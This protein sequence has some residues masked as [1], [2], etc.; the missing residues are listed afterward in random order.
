MANIQHADIPYE[1]MHNAVT[2]QQGN[3]SPIGVVTPLGIGDTYLDTDDNAVY[4][5][6]GETNT[7]WIMLAVGARHNLT[8]GDAPTVDNDNTEGYRRFSHW[9]DQ[10]QDPPDIYLCTDATTGA[11]EWILVSGT[12]GGGGTETYITANDESGSLPNSDT[13]ANYLDDPGVPQVTLT[14]DGGFTTHVKANGSSDTPAYGLE[15]LWQSASFTDRLTM[16]TGITLRSQAPSVDDV[17]QHLLINYLGTTLTS[18]SPTAQTQ[19][20]AALLL[21]LSR[22][23]I[24]ADSYIGGIRFSLRENEAATTYFLNG[25]WVKATENITFGTAHGTKLVFE[26]VPNSGTSPQER[27]TLDHD[28]EVRFH[29]GKIEFG[30]LNTPGSSSA[31]GDAGQ[32]WVD[33]DYL[34]FWTDDDEVK[35]IPWGA[36]QTPIGGAS[37]LDDLSDVTISTPATG[38][39]LRYN[40]SSWV[41]VANMA[42]LATGTYTGDAAT[43]KAITGAGFQ[44]RYLQIWS[45]INGDVNNIVAYKS[46]QDGTRAFY[47][48]AYQNDQ[49]I[50]LD[51]DGFTVGD[52]T[53]A[54]ASNILNVSAR[55]Y[56]WVAFA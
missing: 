46:N 37:A 49:I 10:S 48:N 23:T 28:G 24:N 42:R 47:N 20:P 53:G 38:H 4:L 14:N 35:S 25:I 39:G 50:S 1:H 13:I 15:M 34:Y 16:M 12:G 22:E 27:L 6:Y 11:A 43:T 5:A 30:A 8:A 21:K 17:A 40:G 19:I 31:T 3:G 52:G 45:Q 51:A 33:A 54:G 2:T 26:T 55:V 32:M 36:F 18:E 44:P 9:F 29:T 41:N 7:D 56:T